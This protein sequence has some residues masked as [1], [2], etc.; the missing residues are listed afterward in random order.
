M[1][2]HFPLYLF[3]VPL[4]YLLFTPLP[5]SAQ[6]LTYTITPMNPSIF[7]NHTFAGFGAEWDPFFWNDLGARDGLNATDWTIITNRIKEM[8]VPIIRMWIQLYW[9][10][11]SVNPTA[12]D[13][14]TWDRT[15]TRMQSVYKYLD[16]ACQNNIDVILTDWGWSFWPSYGLFNGNLTDPNFAKAIALMVKDLKVTRGYSCI[17]YFIEGNEPDYEI[18]GKSGKTYTDYINMYKNIDIAFTDA[19]IHSMIQFVGPDPAC[20]QSLMTNTLPSLANIVDGYDFHLYASQNSANTT[21]GYLQDQIDSRRVWLTDILFPNNPS[22]YSKPLFVTEAGLDSGSTNNTWSYA[23]DMADYGVSALLS[24]VQSVIA[25]NMHDI[26]YDYS[27]YSNPFESNELMQWGMWGYKTSN[28]KIR[29]WAQT[30]GLLTKYTPRNSQQTIVSFDGVNTPPSIPNT[31]IRVAAVKRPDNGWSIFFVNRNTI[32]H[33][34]T[35]TIPDSLTHTFDQY[36]LDSS[37]I[38]TYPNQIIP[39]P[40]DTLTTAQAVTVTLSAKSFTVLSESGLLTVSP[41]TSISPSPTLHPNKP[42]DANGDNL[43]DGRDYIVWVNHYGT[44]STGSTNGD[45]NTDS[46]VDGRDYIMWVNNYGK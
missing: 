16:F 5:V 19:G 23:L 28:W 6:T 31:S 9:S 40:T 7:Y 24:R 4:L 8:N 33:T 17:K 20:C 37:T 35:V 41:T 36:S 10:L 29:P 3:F 21:I 2:R 13:P 42:G 39:P 34:V 44:A 25:W 1:K 38:T 14:F 18:I 30:W 11:I 32:S 12:V 22:A 15:N 26:Y 46:V 43:V 27:H 45:F